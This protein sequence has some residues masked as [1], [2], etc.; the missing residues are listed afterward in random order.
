[1]K[2]L[3]IDNYDSFVYN[4]VHYIEQLGDYDVTVKRND[5]LTLAEVD[6]YDKILLSPGPGI[7]SEAGLMLE[8]INQYRTTKPMLGVCLGHQ[9]IAEVMGCELENMDEVLHGVATNLKVI[10]E[11]QLYKGLPTSFKVGRYH[12][13]Q[14]KKESMMP[15]LTITAEDDNGS[16]LSYKHLK[17]PVWGVQ[18]HPESV[19]TEHGLEIIK[20]WLEA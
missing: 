1:M 8:I 20:N 11:D 19:L 10:A 2:I 13:W 7:P 18:Y 15:E 16:I 5:E 12:S 4:L 3:V 14:I 9:A 6:S 17:Y